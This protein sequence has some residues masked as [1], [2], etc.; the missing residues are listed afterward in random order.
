MNRLSKLYFSAAVAA[1]ALVLAGSANASPIDNPGSNCQ[2]RFDVN[3]GL[4]F[5]DFA[6]GEYV[7]DLP[8]LNFITANTLS[9][10]AMTFVGSNM[11]DLQTS[12]TLGSIPVTVKLTFFTLTGTTDLSSGVDIDWVLTATASFT[13]SHEGWTAAN[14]TTAAFTIDES[15]DWGNTTSPT[16]T[17]PAFTG[18]QCNNHVALINSLFGL[19]SDGATLTLYKFSGWNGST[20][21]HGS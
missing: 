19:G 4:P 18:T 10:G 16:F 20:P 5:L 3:P 21:L 6:S 12:V 17:I 14:C 1:S 15:G 13:N 2:F 11:Q 9:N 7:D 8:T